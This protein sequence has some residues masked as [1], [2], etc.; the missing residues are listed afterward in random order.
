MTDFKCPVCRHYTDTPEHELGCAPFLVNA[1][2]IDGQGLCRGCNATEGGQHRHWCTIG[3][4]P[5][6]ATHTRGRAIAADAADPVRH[7][8]SGATRDSAE[9][10]LDFEGFLDPRVLWAFAEYM[11]EHQTQ[12]DGVERSGDNWQKGIPLDAYAQSLI[13]HVVDVWMI[14]RGHR[15]VRPEDGHE[16]TLDEALGACLFNI[17]GYWHETLKA[18]DVVRDEVCDFIP[19]AAM[20]G[21]D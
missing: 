1:E 6:V 5:G 19:D 15:V 18:R 4:R 20:R 7:F 10:K 12:P 9:N 16:V 21:D 2:Q 17:Q 13:R 8:S 11:H 3:P 14:H